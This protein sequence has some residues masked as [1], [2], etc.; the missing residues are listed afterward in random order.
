M[1]DRRILRRLRPVK[2]RRTSREVVQRYCGI[3][4]ATISENRVTVGVRSPMLVFDA[5]GFEQILLAAKRSG[6]PVHHPEDLLDALRWRLLDD[7]VA[8]QA[9]GSPIRGFAP[10]NC[11][12]CW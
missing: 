1:H 11:W 5:V 7:A 3:R 4:F 6:K 10:V 8:Q 9:I 2:R 12:K